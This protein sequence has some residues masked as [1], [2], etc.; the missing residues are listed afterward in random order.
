MQA[1]YSI[2]G[3]ELER[4]IIPLAQDQ[5][6]AILPWSPLAGGFLSGKFTRDNEGSAND[7]RV[8][9]D[10]PPVNKEKGYDIVDVMQE[11]AT[12]REVS[13]AQVALAWLLHKPGVTSV[14]IGAKKMSQLQDNL[15]SVEIE[16]TED[17][18]TQLDEVSQLT[19][20]Y[21]NWLNASP[22]DR[23]PGQK[24]WTDM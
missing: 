16:F 8:K 14:I 10:F 22:S 1:Y 3:R 13:V 7:R 4:E 17:E 23:M 20:E 18:M 11:I 9:F 2:A 15:K 12:A 24:G 6:L 21:P 5:K 19:P